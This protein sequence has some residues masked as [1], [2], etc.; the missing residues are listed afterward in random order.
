MQSE[1]SEMVMV[2]SRLVLGK[3]VQKFM[4]EV[5]TT[6]RRHGVEKY[7][8]KG[9][10]V[11][12]RD[13]LCLGYF[14]DMHHKPPRLAVATGRPLSE[15]LP[16]FVHEFE[17]TMQWIERA[18]AW[19]NQ[20]MSP[21]SYALDLLGEW[22]AGREMNNEEVAR[23]IRLAREVERDCEE[24][25]VRA[26][27]EYQLPIDSVKYAK[28]ANAYVFSYTAMKETQG[29]YVRSPRDVPEILELMPK[30][31]LQE[32]AYEKLPAGY[33]DALQKHC[34]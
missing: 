22:F 19:T 21:T 1:H 3:P 12:Y 32:G 24:R 34:F 13:L 17:H 5:A 10:Q 29:W 25:T 31:I 26:I 30:Q 20:V 18:P 2:I 27:A 6:C 9:K 23:L 4:N 16:I 8:G 33:V 28:Q 15:W 14:D 7:L 11:L